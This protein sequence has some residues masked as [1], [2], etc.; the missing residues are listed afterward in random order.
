[1]YLFKPEINGREQFRKGGSLAFVVYHRGI[2]ISGTIRLVLVAFKIRTQR[3]NGPEG[4]GGSGWF[5][6]DEECLRRNQPGSGREEEEE[7]DNESLEKE[8][9][10]LSYPYKR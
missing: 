5:D 6:D 3:E 1:M 8:E 4:M 9:Q 2:A 7:Q 10:G